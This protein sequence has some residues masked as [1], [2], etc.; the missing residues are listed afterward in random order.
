MTYVLGHDTINDV[1]IAP[2]LFQFLHCCE[3]YLFH[4]SQLV[5]RNDISCNHFLSMVLSFLSWLHLVPPHIHEFKCWWWPWLYDTKSSALSPNEC[6]FQIVSCVKC[7]LEWISHELSTLAF[8][9]FTI[10]RNRRQTQLFILIHINHLFTI[11]YTHI[12]APVVMKNEEILQTLIFCFGWSFTDTH[13]HYGRFPI[14]WRWIIHKSQINT[15]SI[16]SWINELLSSFFLPKPLFS[17]F[18]Y[19]SLVITDLNC[20]LWVWFLSALL[21]RF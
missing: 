10:L 11:S 6:M 14:F 16:G 21:N 7:F 19:L 2:H 13:L 18:F 15:F 5:H 4:V 9:C 8:S 1:G 12:L 17:Y 3:H 20:F